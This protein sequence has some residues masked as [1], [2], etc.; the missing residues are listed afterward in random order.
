MMPKTLKHFL[1]YTVLRMFE[2]KFRKFRGK[3]QNLADFRMT[4]IP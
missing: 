2:R 3:C 4:L 1:R